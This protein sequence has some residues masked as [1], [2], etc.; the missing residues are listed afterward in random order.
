VSPLAAIVGRP[1]AV[2]ARDG[3][4]LDAREWSAGPSVATLVVVPGGAERLEAFDAW[5]AVLADHGIDVRAVRTRLP[6]AS[7]DWER[8]L[9]DLEDALAPPGV[10]PANGLYAEG[11]AATL[12]GDYLLSARRQ[13]AIAW[14]VGPSPRPPSAGGSFVGRLLGRRPG[15]AGDLDLAVAGARSRAI[16]GLG[17]IATPLEVWLGPQHLLDDRREWFAMPNQRPGLIRL[18]DERADPPHRTGDWRGRAME[19]VQAFVGHPDRLSE[20]GRGRVEAGRRARDADERLP[21]AQALARLADHVAGEPQRV[22]RFVATV[23][24][25]GGPEPGCSREAMA[26]LGAWLIDALEEGPADGPVPWWADS[27]HLGV[28]PTSRMS[29]ATLWLLDG[30][31]AWF[32]DCYRAATPGLAWELDTYRRSVTYHRPVLG[33]LSPPHPAPVVVR[34]ARADPPDRDWL[35]R[36][37][38]AYTSQPP[39]PRSAEGPTLDEVLDE[40]AVEPSDHAGWDVTIWLPEAT[41]AV[42]GERA[43]ERL[44]AAIR[45]LP[46]IRELAWEDREVMLAQLEP[47]VAPEAVRQRVVGVVRRAGRR[48]GAD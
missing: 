20:A 12:A 9:D 15:A 24:E 26:A 29:T 7:A 2:R 28:G 4:T 27:W 41:E 1:A 5:A 33:A 34:A 42:V 37:W 47:G 13:P 14:L 18:Y 21:R 39:G 36:I 8:A 46:G 19:V 17:A 44:E 3:A 43:F 38:D 40:L 10:P 45:S 32:A 48:V 31:S 30:L 22:R 6:G 35:A 25:L 11:L 16:A 23:R